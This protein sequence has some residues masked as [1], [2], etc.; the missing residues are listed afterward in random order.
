MSF[1]KIKGQ[2]RQIGI[3][4]NAIKR[5]T[6]SHAYLFTGISGIGK[7]TTATTMA[8]ALNCEVKNGDF[9]NCCISCKKIEH[10]THPDI[11]WI[12]PEGNYIKIDQIRR[13]QE[14]IKYTLYEGKSKVVIIDKAEKMNPQSSNCLLK[15]LEEPPPHTV[16]LLLTTAPYL[17]LPTI[18]SRCQKIIFQPLSTELIVAMLTEKQGGKNGEL[19]LI[20]SLAGGS[21]GKAMQWMEGDALKERKS[22]LEKFNHLHRVHVTEIFDL[23]ESLGEDRETLTDFFDLLRLW[24]RDLLIFKETGQPTYLINKDFNNEVRRKSRLLSYSDLFEKTQILNDTQLAL[25]FNVNPKLAMETMLLK[26]C[27]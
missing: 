3:L 12:E 22:L 26:L 9:S 10:H 20:A 24:F 15:T 4:I 1:E 14:Q 25:Y 8:K 17:L 7:M 6:V 11:H 21:I 19:K 18:R 23:A 5:G 27:Q 2:D 16:L 13:M